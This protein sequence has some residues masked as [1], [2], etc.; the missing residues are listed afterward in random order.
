M[1]YKKM[2]LIRKHQNQDGVVEMLRFDDFREGIWLK[3]KFELEPES[4]DEVESVDAIP[5][6]DPDLDGT[7]GMDLELALDEA[8]RQESDPKDSNAA[9]TEVNASSSNGKAGRTRS[10][11]RLVLKPLPPDEAGR[12]SDE[13]PDHHDGKPARKVKVQEVRGQ[14]FVCPHMGYMLPSVSQN[15]LEH[16]RRRRCDRK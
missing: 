6:Q 5:V 13:K 14:E 16:S 12:A 8:L 3:E 2:D 11:F 1:F 15:L 9:T 10:N 7:E 4:C